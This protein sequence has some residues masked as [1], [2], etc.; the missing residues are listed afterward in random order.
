MPETNVYLDS[1]GRERQISVKNLTNTSFVNVTTDYDERGNKI[2]ESQP[3]DLS[4]FDESDSIG[5]G[6]LSYDAL[7]RLQAKEM[8][9]ADGTVFLTSY[10]YQV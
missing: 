10:S 6:Y 7:G 3:Y 5:T 1:L 8:D 2:F 4:V 9:Q